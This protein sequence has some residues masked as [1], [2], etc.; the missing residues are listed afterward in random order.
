MSETVVAP[1]FVPATRLERL[2][3]AAE[4]G[5]DAIIIDLED[6]VA[7]KD[8]VAARAALATAILPDLPIILRVNGATTPWHEED[9][10]AAAAGRFAAVMLPKSEDAATIATMAAGLGDGLA[11]LALVETARGLAHLGDV[12]TAPGVRRLVFGS[13]DFSSDLGCAHEPEPLLFARTQIVLASRVAGLA[14]PLDGVTLAVDDVAAVEADARRAVALGFSGKLCIHPRQV[15]PAFRGFS[16]SAAELAW[17]ETVLSAEEGGAVA[18][19]GTMI[20][21]PVRRRAEQIARRGALLARLGVTGPS[22]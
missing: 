22:R 20:D 2:T 14:A 4:S 1:L 17:A 13:V 18:V 5:A 7:A 11:I 19:G 10:R 6:A 16:P 15:A 8:K 12:A 9:L 3:K 21:A